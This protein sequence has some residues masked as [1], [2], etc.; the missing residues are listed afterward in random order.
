M[1][2]ACGMSL[3]VWK[4]RVRENIIKKEMKEVLYIGIEGKYSRAILLEG[5]KVL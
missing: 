1:A 2:A 3:N 4:E 5:K